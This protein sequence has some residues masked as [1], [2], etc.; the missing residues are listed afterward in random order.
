MS[1]DVVVLIASAVRLRAIREAAVFPYRVVPFTD[2]DLSSALGSIATHEPRTIALDVEFASTPEGRAFIDRL[3][4]LPL[5]TSERVILS[6]G[7]DRWSLDP[8]SRSSEPSITIGAALVTPSGLVP[9]PLNKR[10]VPR[11]PIVHEVEAIV[12]GKKM[13]LVDMST[14]GAQVI[15]KPWIRPNQR[16]TVALPDE[17]NEFLTVTA[18][19]AWSRFEASPDHPGAHY[20]RAGME[21]TDASAQDLEAYCRRHCADSPIPPPG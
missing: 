1:Q 4:T 7:S 11:F 21:F 8:L 3:Q 10:R 6:F 20:Y 15:S 5:T 17:G 14:L 19:V 16:L 18:H 12:D 9:V 2:S 13:P